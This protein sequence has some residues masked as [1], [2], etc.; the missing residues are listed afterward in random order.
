MSPIAERR[1]HELHGVDAHALPDEVLTSTRPLVLR[2]L[3]AHWPAV[4]AAQAT[5]ASG[6]DYLRQF[7]VGSTVAAMVGAPDIGGRFFYNDDLSGFNFHMERPPLRAML[8]A[9]ARHLDDAAPPALYVGSTT[10]DTCLPGFRGANDVGM[11][12]RDPLVSIWLGNRTRIAA[13]QDLPDNLACAVA[14]RR[15]FTLFPP[16]QLA[17]LYIGP[18]DLTPA[19]QAISVVDFKQ[20][21]LER[22]PRFAQALEHAQVAD[23]EPGDAIFIPSMWWHH[24]EA[25]DAFNVLVNYWWRQ[26]PAYMD[27]PMNALMLAIMSVR[28]LPDEQRRAWQHAF[29]HYVFEADDRTAAH[30]PE[31]ARRVLAPLDEAR[32]RELRARLLKRINR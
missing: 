1:V 29:E 23:L 15:R 18:L 32:A 11:G 21:D 6:I 4:R 16:E 2:G 19:G 20:P 25:L 13:H 9:L 27:S 3:V 24:V 28:D 14:G 17:N 12:G 8:D 30:I 26:S 10:V 31:P 22:F 7:D 5:P